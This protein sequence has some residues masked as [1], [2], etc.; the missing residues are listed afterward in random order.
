VTDV[1]IRDYIEAIIENNDRRY[2]SEREAD[3]IA[4]LDY[5]K[6]VSDALLLA[7]SNADRMIAM[8]ISVAALL[9]SAVTAIF[10]YVKI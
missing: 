7:K 1:S 4:L 5:K 6:S 10:V 3:R 8:L 9:I 2:S